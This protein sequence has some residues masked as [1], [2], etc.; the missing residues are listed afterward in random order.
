MSTQTI[1]IRKVDV[2]SEQDI[3]PTK[4][5]LTARQ[6]LL[7][8]TRELRRV[9]DQLSPQCCAA[10]WAKTVEQSVFDAP[11]NHVL[12][13]E[14]L[15]PRDSSFLKCSSY[16]L[17]GLVGVPLIVSVCLLLQLHKLPNSSLSYSLLNAIVSILFNFSSSALLK[18][19]S[20]LIGLL[21]FSRWFTS[22]G[23]NVGN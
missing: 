22:S 20:F 1:T 4:D 15:N 14:L 12:R 19:F 13:T 23:N 7:N 2:L 3:N 6:H 5:W 11:A 8:R 17:L 16:H 21:G 9:R 18:A 10:K